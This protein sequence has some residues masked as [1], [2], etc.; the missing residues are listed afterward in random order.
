MEVMA[1][2]LL[3]SRSCLCSFCSCHAVTGNI[4]ICDMLNMLT[5][6][7]CPCHLNC[8]MDKPSTFHFFDLQLPET[9]SH[10]LV[11]MLT[12]LVPTTCQDSSFG[13][14]SSLCRC[15]YRH[16]CTYISIDTCMC[17]VHPVYMY[18]FINTPFQ[19]PS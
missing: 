16:V 11:H 2:T 8:K 19:N 5:S 7:S 18:M 14:I 10:I 9:L 4:S 6:I 3:K 13:T 1:I 15:P 12:V 17:V